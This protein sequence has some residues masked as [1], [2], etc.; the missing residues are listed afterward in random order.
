VL[1]RIYRQFHYRWTKDWQASWLTKLLLSWRY[2]CYVSL[3]AGVYH[4]RKIR[5]GRNVQI[6]ERTLLNFRSGYDK[7]D[8]NL[9]IGDGTKVLPDAKLIPQ[10]GF[11][12]IG[13]NCTV[14]YGCL[15]YGVGGLQIGDNTR[16][17]AYTIMTPMN[18][19][20]SDPCMPIWKQGETAQGIKIGSDVWIGSNVKILDGVEIGDGCVIGAGSVVTKSI[21]PYSI[22]VGVPAKVI[23]HRGQSAPPDAG[24]GVASS[25]SQVSEAGSR[26]PGNRTPRA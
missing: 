3:G 19:V 14:Q 9:E 17:A 26:Q 18:H 24:L 23:K 15:L 6:Y 7:F 11:I 5:L 21:P 4:P 1:R 12:R 20:Y 10:Q 25:A 16:I 8:V 13:R 22:A 2:D